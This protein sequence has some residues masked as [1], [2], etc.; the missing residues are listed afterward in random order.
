MTFQF[1]DGIIEVAEDMG[2][3]QVCVEASTFGFVDEIE[4]ELD[5]NDVTARGMNLVTIALHLFTHNYTQ[6]KVIT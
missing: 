5:Y 4:I 2:T 6:G 3:I 1:V